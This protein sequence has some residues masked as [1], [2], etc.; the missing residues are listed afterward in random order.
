MSVKYIP[1]M[2]DTHPEIGHAYLLYHFT[3][4]T[5]RTLREG[6]NEQE[7]E[8]CV[9]EAGAPGSQL[10][11]PGGGWRGQLLNQGKEGPQRLCPVEGCKARGTLLAFS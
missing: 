11:S 5:A 1:S 6:C 8:S 10:H 9:W 2:H 4:G 7:E 3:Q